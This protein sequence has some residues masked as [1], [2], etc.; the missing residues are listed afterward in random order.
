M[1]PPIKGI[2]P[3]KF[4]NTSRL[5]GPSEF[6]FSDIRHIVD[7]SASSSAQHRYQFV[8]QSRARGVELSGLLWQEGAPTPYRGGSEADLTRLS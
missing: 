3:P 5:P 7:V 1:N 4:L 6:S 2:F 8:E